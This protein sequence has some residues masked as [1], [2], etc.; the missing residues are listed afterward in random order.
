MER[1]IRV[2][3]RKDIVE[4]EEVPPTSEGYFPTELLSEE[5]SAIEIETQSEF[6]LRVFHGVN[7]Y[8][9]CSIDFEQV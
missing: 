2:R 8:D 4:R 6:N 1:M 7:F 3:V 5:L 9:V